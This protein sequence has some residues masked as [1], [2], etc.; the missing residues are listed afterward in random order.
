LFKK[1]DNMEQLSMG[2]I[3]VNSGIAI[4]VN[5]AGDTITINAE[6]QSFIDRFYGMIEKLQEMTKEM[7]ASEM[8]KK[9]ERDSLKIMIE[10]TREIM[11]D[12]DDL[13]GADS[14]KKVFGDIVP[15]AYLIADFF[16]QLTP[17]AEK[18]IGERRKIIENRYSRRRKGA[19]SNV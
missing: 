2:K 17:I 9:G 8:E 14:C 16:D 11:K 7:E 13:F 6:D 15:S 10:R 18:Y 12:I 1:E 19:R 4:E 5:D 3:R